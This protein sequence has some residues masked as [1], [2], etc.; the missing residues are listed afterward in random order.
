MN[1]S[2]AAEKHDAL[3]KHDYAVKLSAVPFADATFKD[4]LDVITNGNAVKPTGKI[5]GLNGYVCAN[6][7]R[8]ADSD[9]R[10]VIYY[11]LTV[12]RKP[13]LL[14]LIAIPVLAGVK[15]TLCIYANGFSLGER[16]AA[17]TFIL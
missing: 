1:T 14:I 2:L 15:D 12:L 10:S 8:T 16:A 11:V 3:I 9:N 4:K 5:N 7:L 6:Y 13:N 17:G